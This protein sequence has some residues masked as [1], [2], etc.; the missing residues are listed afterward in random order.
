MIQFMTF[1]EKHSRW[2][3][4]LLGLFVLAPITPYLD[5]KLSG[6]FYDP[7]SS[8]FTNNAFYYLVYHYAQLPGFIVFGAA[9]LGLCLS[10]IKKSLTP[11]RNSFLVLVLAMAIGPGLVINVLLKPGWGR[12]RP[13]QIEEF[14][15][16]EKYR[17]FYAPNFGYNKADK[18][19]S[20]PSGHA[21]MG[22]Y[23]F[24]FAVM[25][26]R[27][28]DRRMVYAA[29]ATAL[30]LGIIL[31]ITRIAQGG[32]FFS[33]IIVAVLVTWWSA[34]IVDWMIFSDA[35]CERLNRKTA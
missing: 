20:F 4:P 14:S 30:T 7:K 31:G 6:F 19:K 35:Y 17:A 27:V 33:D 29:T 8:T 15:G 13:R 28:G 32:H 1:V 5:I 3:V 24:V 2:I 10:Y 11:Y 21:S 16:S 22:F 34:L 25:G 26:A 23:F 18:Y 12:P 9:L